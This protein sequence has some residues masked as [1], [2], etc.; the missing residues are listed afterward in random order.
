[1]S[2]NSSCNFNWILHPD[3]ILALNSCV[4]QT[5]ARSTP[6]G[7]YIS[8]VRWGDLQK[9]SSTFANIGAFKHLHL[10]LSTS[11]GLILSHHN[12]FWRL[13]RRGFAIRRWPLIRIHASYDKG[14][15]ISRSLVFKWLLETPGCSVFLHKYHRTGDPGGN[16]CLRCS[17]LPCLPSSKGTSWV[18]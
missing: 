13:S 7:G 10:H 18:R 11:N 2:L 15:Q 17:L 3:S 5:C 4:V 6:R 8:L 12:S 16:I 1:M 9:E 14:N